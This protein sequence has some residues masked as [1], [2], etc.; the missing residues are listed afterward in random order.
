MLPPLSPGALRRF[1]D[2]TRI[3]DVMPV[4]GFGL[5]TSPV[6]TTPAQPMLRMTIDV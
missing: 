2:C 1:G 3:S 5:R 4:V 6:D